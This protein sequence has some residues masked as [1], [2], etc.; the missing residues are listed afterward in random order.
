M[1]NCWRPPIRGKQMIMMPFVET[2]AALQSKEIHQHILHIPCS[3][4]LHRPARFQDFPRAFEVLVSTLQH[5]RARRTSL[6]FIHNMPHITNRRSRRGFSLVIILEQESYKLVAFV[7]FG[8]VT[9]SYLSL[10]HAVNILIFPDHLVDQPCIFCLLN[11]NNI[12]PMILTFG[13][14]KR[15]R[16]VV[17]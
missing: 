11:F 17:C 1:G 3:H 9:A 4:S 10:Q 14:H 8:C 12:L 15:T 16:N 7:A 2:D 5:I 13:R 6:S